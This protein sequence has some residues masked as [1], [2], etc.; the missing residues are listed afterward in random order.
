MVSGGDG[1]SDALGATDRPV[2]LKGSGAFNRGCVGA[3][4]HIDIVGTAVA[5]HLALLGS[6]AGWVVCAE[7][8]DDVVLNERIFGPAVESEVAVAV[9]V[10]CSRIL[11]S[12]VCI[13]SLLKPLKY[14]GSYLG[15][16]G[17]HPFPPTKLPP[18]CH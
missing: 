15:P 1:S 3:S 16:P 8:F 2:L 9:W 10:V 6:T 4:A 11:D 17:F 14:K 5:G 7:G 18:V 12:S 13:V